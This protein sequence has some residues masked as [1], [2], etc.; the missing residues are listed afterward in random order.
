MILTADNYYSPEADKTFMSNSQYSNF[1]SCEAMAIAKINGEWVDPLNESYEVGSFTHAWNEGTLDKF[2]DNNPH[3]FSSRGATKGEL[4][5][6]YQVANRMIATLEADPFCMKALEGEKEVIM[7]AEMFGTPWKIK[8]DSYNREIRRI[9]DLKA[10][11]SIQELIWSEELRAKTNFVEAYHYD[12]QLIIYTEVE[13][14]ATRNEDW[15]APLIVAV[16]KEE[17]CDKAV[18]DVFDANHMMYTLAAIGSVMP[19]IMDVKSGKVKPMRCGKCAYCRSTKQ[20]TS[21]VF[22]RDLGMV[23]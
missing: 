18:I 10:M 6:P 13:R 17:P 12:R 1:L 5:A 20:L 19:H 21:T 22:Y 8:I 7:T 15:G 11:K 9:V 23:S 16:S 3:I 2:K 14:I 4:K